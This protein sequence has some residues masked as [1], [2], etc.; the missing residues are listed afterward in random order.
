MPQKN[1]TGSFFLADPF[2]V[3]RAFSSQLNIKLPTSGY[4]GAEYDPILQHKIEKG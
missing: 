1:R 2:G 4:L 3:D